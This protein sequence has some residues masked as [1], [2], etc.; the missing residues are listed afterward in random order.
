[1][2]R[3]VDGSFQL[4]NEKPTSGAAFFAAHDDQE[5]DATTH[6]QTPDKLSG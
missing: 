5:I 3:V 1:V 6:T 2:V 4:S